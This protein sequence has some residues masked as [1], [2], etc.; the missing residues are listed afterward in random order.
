MIPAPARIFSPR[1]ARTSWRSIVVWQD[2]LALDG[3]RVCQAFFRKATAFVPATPPRP[4]QGWRV[5]LHRRWSEQAHRLKPLLRFAHVM[6]AD[7]ARPGPTNENDPRLAEAAAK[8]LTTK[9]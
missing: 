2:I 3:N 1:C 6:N 4:F 9:G 5:L 8:L 7:P